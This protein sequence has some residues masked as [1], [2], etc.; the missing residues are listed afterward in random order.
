MQ[1]ASYKARPLVEIVSVFLSS[2]LYTL[3]AYIYAN[4]IIRGLYPYSV[5][6]YCIEF[7]LHNCSCHIEAPLSERCL[8]SLLITFDRRN[9]LWAS[10]AI[11]KIA[12]VMKRQRKNLM[13]RLFCVLVTDSTTNAARNPEIQ[14]H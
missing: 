6:L 13:R 8:R 7:S 10:P 5:S 14:H 4:Y 3:G 11:L 2:A 9:K 12:F 1:I